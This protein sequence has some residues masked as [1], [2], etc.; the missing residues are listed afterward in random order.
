MIHKLNLQLFADGGG[1]GAAGEAVAGAVE[2][3]ETVETGEVVEAVEQTAEPIDRNAEFE[4][5]IKSDY[6]DLY[7]ERVQRRIDERF[8][9]TRTLEG[10]LKTLDPVLNLLS[11]KYGEKDLA[12][13]VKA[14]EEDNSYYETEAFDKGVSVEQLKYM[15]QVERENAEFKRAAEERE[16]K[17]NQERMFAQW[18]EQSEKTKQIYP[19]MDF[20]NEVNN[21]E[22]GHKFIGLLHNGIDVKTAY[23]VIHKDEIVGGAMQ[24]T[25]QQ[26]QKKTVNDI[27][28]RGQRPSENAAGSQSTAQLKKTDVSKM[29][30]ADRDSLAERA[31]RGE[32]I[33]FD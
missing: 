24:Y 12:K 14:I 22:T 27:L 33:T 25:A 21:P 16:Q 2:S 15:K 7:D 32:R 30:K 26:V 23:E 8:K 9:E 4:K 28:A 3:V 5:L 31:R 6:K 20:R 13:L 19:N 1:D 10:K 11:E 18:V 29:T 17:A